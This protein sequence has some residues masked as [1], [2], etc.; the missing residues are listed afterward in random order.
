ML[1][2]AC[3]LYGLAAEELSEEELTHHDPDF[4]LLMT[5]R[6]VKRDRDPRRDEHTQWIRSKGSSLSGTA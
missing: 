2:A 3:F 6:A 5:I 1:L 4:E